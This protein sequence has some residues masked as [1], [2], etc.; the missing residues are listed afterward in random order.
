[1]VAERAS[2]G[3]G[4]SPLLRCGTKPLSSP[5][6]AESILIIKVSSKKEHLSALLHTQIS[7]SQQNS[8]RTHRSES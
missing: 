4:M 1:M 5:Y 8:P 6:Q 3:V 7:L 2:P